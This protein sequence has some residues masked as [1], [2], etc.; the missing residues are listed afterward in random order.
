MREIKDVRV[1]KIEG[2]EGGGGA[3]GGGGGGGESRWGIDEDD[4]VG[5]YL[6]M[7]LQ[8]KGRGKAVF[9]VEIEGV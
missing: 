4:E 5:A 3:G 8:G 7:V 9:V 6:E 2:V 1:G